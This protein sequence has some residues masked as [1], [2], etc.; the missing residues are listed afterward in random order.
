MIQPFPLPQEFHKVI[1]NS[2]EVPLATASS[3]E[4]VPMWMV[5]G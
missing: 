2:D 3:P 4:Q 5:S 1:E